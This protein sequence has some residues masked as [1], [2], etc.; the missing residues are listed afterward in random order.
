MQLGAVPSGE[1]FQAH[2]TRN[3]T[4]RVLGKLG[5]FVE[6]RAKVQQCGFLFFG[7]HHIAAHAPLI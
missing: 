1:V 7:K 3:A 5:V 4:V 2:L 6:E